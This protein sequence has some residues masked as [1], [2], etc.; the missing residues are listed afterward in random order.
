MQFQAT[1]PLGQALAA[2]IAILIAALAEHAAEHPLLA[3][4]LRATIRQLEAIVRRFDALAAEWQ[5]TRDRP[6]PRRRA[7][8]PIPELRPP[9][10]TPGFVPRL[11]PARAR[12]PPRAILHA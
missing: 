3:P 12:A 8:L 6:R 7:K 9:H 11:P 1:T 4:S 5:A 2:I 10:P